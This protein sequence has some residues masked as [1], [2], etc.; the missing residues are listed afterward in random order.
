M[1]NISSFSSTPAGRL[2][3][4]VIP[5][6]LLAM[7]AG[8]QGVRAQLIY[9]GG[10]GEIEFSGQGV[11]AYGGA[12]PLWVPDAFTGGNDILSSPGGGFNEVNYA[13]SA[14][15]DT[16]PVVLGGGIAAAL[17]PGVYG[18][19]PGVPPGTPFGGGSIAI[20]PTSVGFSI[21]EV[22][23]GFVSAGAAA[24]Q[25]SFTVGPLGIG[26]PTIGTFLA[27]NGIVN[28][29]SAIAASLVTYIDDVTT[30]NSVALVEVLGATGIT[31]PQNTVALSGAFGAPAAVNG[32]LVYGAPVGGV[33]AYAGLAAASVANFLNVGD[34][35]L[36][37][38]VLTEAADPDATINTGSLPGN[39]DGVTLP[40]DLLFDTQPVPE[41]ATWSLLAVSVLGFGLRRR[42][43]VPA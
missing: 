17:A 24:Q 15:A 34:N 21:G 4:L 31:P 29:N 19:L 43:I 11:A 12:P 32:F 5:V 16:G 33:E 25:S 36:I 6:A 1:N 3:S 9:N 41:P 28:P 23:P 39:L 8:P 38:A 10:T 27:I 37:T 22:A 18:P 14:I 13:N 20:G 42:G 35:V 26:A 7:V 2:V 40:G 30:G